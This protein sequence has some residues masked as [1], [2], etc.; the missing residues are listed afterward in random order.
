TVNIQNVSPATGKVI[1][2][3]G[4]YPYQIDVIN[5]PWKITDPISG[6]RFPTND[7]GAYYA[8]GLVSSGTFNPDL[9]DRSLLINTLYPEKGETWGVDDGFGW[10]DENGDRYP[11]I[12][13]YVHWGL[14][15]Y[16]GK[17][18][19]QQAL[20]N[21]R[22][23]YIYTDDIQYARAGIVL[24]DR[25]ADVY[26]SQDISMHSNS[27]DNSHGG[28]GKGKAVGSILETFLVKDFLYAY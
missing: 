24:L 4:V 14:W 6:Y 23:A 17:S 2:E 10:V 3:F 8:S 22:D 21:L 18:F 19:I 11:F 20:R 12:A 9:A 5:D 28:T 7:F 27:Y 25:I 26:P 13:Y 1:D 16:T 15:G